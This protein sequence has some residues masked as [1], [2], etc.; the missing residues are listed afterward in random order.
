M[1]INVVK[2]FNGI[3]LNMNLFK[4]LTESFKV[5]SLVKNEDICT[6]F[7]SHN[8][9]SNVNFD[10]WISYLTNKTLTLRM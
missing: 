5:V 10:L 1:L 2:G 3:L 8:I 7:M 4:S 6:V 9:I